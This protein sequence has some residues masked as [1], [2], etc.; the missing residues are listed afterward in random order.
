MVSAQAVNFYSGT[1]PMAFFQCALVGCSPSVTSNFVGSGAAC[2]AFT[3]G[4]ATFAENDVQPNAAAVPSACSCQSTRGY[5]TTQAPA[6]GIVVIYKDPGC[7]TKPLKLTR[8]TLCD[9]FSGRITNWKQIPGCAN[10]DL[11]VKRCVR[12]DSSGT[13]TSFTRTLKCMCPTDPFN[14]PCCAPGPSAP[15]SC[16]S[17]TPANGN[18]NWPSSNTIYNSG[19][20]A[21]GSCVKNNIGSFGY[22]A[23]SQYL[24]Y[25]SGTVTAA[26]LQAADGTFV[27]PSVALVKTGVAAIGCGADCY[28]PRGWP[29][30][31]LPSMIYKSACYGGALKTLMKKICVNT[32]A[33]KGCAGQNCVVSPFVPLPAAC[34]TKY[35]P[36]CNKIC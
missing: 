25:V 28:A 3:S 5:L 11:P 17:A 23:Y 15:A 8:Q 32:L 36:V 18:C 31:V 21:V 34:K 35:N 30:C 4:Q 7:S 29:M 20:P 16:E 14:R 22:V 1:F 13:T 2:D 12:C 10:K 33:G 24:T 27:S 19:N 9:I 26:K 6:S